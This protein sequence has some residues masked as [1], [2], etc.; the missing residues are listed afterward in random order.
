MD[1]DDVT[2][3]CYKYSSTIDVTV[4]SYG[5]E[6]GWKNLAIAACFINPGLDTNDDSRPGEW[7]STK[8]WSISLLALILWQ[9]MTATLTVFLPV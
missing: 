5:I 4:F 8:I 9:L 6:S 3:S 1:A 7:F 2:T